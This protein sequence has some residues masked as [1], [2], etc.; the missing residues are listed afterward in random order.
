MK[1][2]NRY[3]WLLMNCIVSLRLELTQIL[4]ETTGFS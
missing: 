2:T 3:G 4:P 1:T